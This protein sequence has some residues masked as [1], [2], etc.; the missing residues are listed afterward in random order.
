M[1]EIR[2]VTLDCAGTLV[3]VNWQPEVFASDCL[4]AQG[5][6][7]DRADAES[8]YRRILQ[9]RWRTYQ[10]LN[11]Q[12][13]ETVGDGFWRALTEDWLGKIGVASDPLDAVM[14]LAHRR[15]YQHPSAAFSLYEDTLPTLQALRERGLKLAVLSNWDYSLHRVLRLLELT[16]YFECVVAS[17]EEGVEKPEPR[18]FEIV[19]ERLGADPAE[20]IHVGDDPL[21][22]EVGAKRV[23]IQPVLLDRDG[24]A[25][26]PRRIRDLSQVIEVLD[27]T[28]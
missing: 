16:P 12:R 1:S 5:V 26:I 23:G 21:D 11:L 22:D 27:W 13:D 4:A 18:I 7:F 2:F 19:L 20:T 9:T 14:E 24:L 15:L 3:H 25:Q 6:E 17:L 8:T 28:G 10:E